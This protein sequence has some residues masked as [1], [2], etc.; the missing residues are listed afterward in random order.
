MPLGASITF[1]QG[2]SDRN[3]YRRIL[4]EALVRLGFTVNMV[5]SRSGGTMT[6][7]Q[8]EGWPGFTISEVLDKAR[9]PES[10]PKWQ[11]NLV[12]IQVGSNDLNQGIDVSSTH[13]RLLALLE[14]LWEASPGCTVVL[15][16]L[17]NNANANIMKN[18]PA[19]N[20]RIAA[21]AADQRAKGKRLVH[22]DM[23]GADGP[24]LADIRSDGTHPNDAGFAKMAQVFLAGIREAV[25]AGFIQ[26]AKNTG[27]PD[28]GGA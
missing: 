18:V 26:R 14:Y 7:N 1:G 21:M 15:A 3:G 6:D 5:G 27:E 8:V 12:L 17:L 16:N 10:V 23:R 24:A 22:V 4:R 28:D 20:E 25:A 19:V 13:L 11:P 9:Q 2:S